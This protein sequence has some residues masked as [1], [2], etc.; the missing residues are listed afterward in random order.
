MYDLFLDKDLDS[1][2]MV[3][4]EDP[5]HDDFDADPFLHLLELYEV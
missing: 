5:T 2:S 1:Q 3:F 4:D